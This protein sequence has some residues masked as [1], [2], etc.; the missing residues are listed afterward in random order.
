MGS[1]VY[2]KNDIIE[3]RIN[4]P[5][6]R[7]PNA[8]N[9]IKNKKHKSLPVNTFKFNKRPEFKQ[10]KKSLKTLCLKDISGIMCISDNEDDFSLNENNTFK[11]IIE[12]F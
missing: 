3:V 2:N 4:N 8:L 9:N 1:C 10:S 6:E 5:S 11:K 7:F 12:I